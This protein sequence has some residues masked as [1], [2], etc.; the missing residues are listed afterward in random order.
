MDRRLAESSHEVLGFSVGNKITDEEMVEITRAIDQSISN[1]AKIRLLLV[2]EPG[3]P[4]EPDAL[5]EDLRFV[6]T[7]A[8]SLEH[9]AIIGDQPWEETWIQLAG[10]FGGIEMR[11]FHHS[12]LEAARQW[13]RE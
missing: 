9:V 5:L 12:Q 3:R 4:M 7:Y 6:K 10:L 13:L 1:R 2:I 8:E 11:Y